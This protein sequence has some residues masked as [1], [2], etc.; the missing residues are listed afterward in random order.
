MEKIVSSITNYTEA[1]IWLEVKNATCGL[2]IK[3]GSTFDFGP[4]C[5]IVINDIVINPEYCRK[6]ESEIKRLKK[7]V[8][9][10]IRGQAK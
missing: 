1:P 7:K 2:L 5:E 9:R 8:N 3:S 10:L 6:S 4:W